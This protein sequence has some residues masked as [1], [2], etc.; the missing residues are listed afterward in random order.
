MNN[1]MIEKIIQSNGEMCPQLLYKN[2]IIDKEVAKAMSKSFVKILNISKDNSNIN[3][4]LRLSILENIR[5]LCTVEP[6]GHLS[7]DESVTEALSGLFI[8]QLQ[9]TSAESNTMASADK[10]LDAFLIRRF[11]SLNI[12]SQYQPSINPEI[13]QALINLNEIGV[14]LEVL[15]QHIVHLNT[16]KDNTL[17]L[18]K[19][20]WSCDEVDKIFDN[21]DDVAI[22][23]KPEIEKLLLG[24][25][26]SILSDPNINIENLF[27]N[28]YLTQ[29][30]TRS[31]S[32]AE[33][34]QICCSILNYLF[35]MT[36]FDSKLQTFIQSFANQVKARCPKITYSVLYPVHINYV[37]VLLDI[38]INELPEPFKGSYVTPTLKHLQNVRDNN[39]N[40]FIMLLSHF[41]QWFDVY[42][43]NQ[44]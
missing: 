2:P 18:M 29:L 6:E 5:K 24:I 37:V 44:M 7:V 30:L 32:S 25:C 41:P 38:E 39:E 31:S 9:S 17:N 16:E 23:M 34:Y 15:S 8:D 11:K 43:Q 21:F 27:N 3:N 35:I 33:C 36:N 14:Y 26:H 28:S 40:D 1:Q 22:K 4:N 20:L 10:D 13:I 42:F 12:E 19:A